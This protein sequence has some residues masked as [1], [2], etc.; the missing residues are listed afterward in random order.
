[1]RDVAVVCDLNT[2][3]ESRSSGIRRMVIVM[4]FSSTPW[5]TVYRRQATMR[6]KLRPGPA[7]NVSVKNLTV[8]LRTRNNYRYY[9][10]DGHRLPAPK[11]AG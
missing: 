3:P 4:L 1:M 10:Y 8:T 11:R 5:R 7:R 9:C 2:E 6:T